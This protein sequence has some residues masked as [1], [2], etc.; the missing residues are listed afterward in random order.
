[1]PFKLLLRQA[2]HQL[3]GIEPIHGRNRG[4]G[5]EDETER[6]GEPPAQEAQ[7]GWDE[8]RERIGALVASGAL[9]EARTLAEEAQAEMGAHEVRSEARGIATVLDALEEGGATQTESTR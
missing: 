9:D 5:E 6:A 8:M 3:G 7:A 1:M 2:S 4:D